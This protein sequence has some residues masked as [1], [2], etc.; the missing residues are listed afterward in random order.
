MVFS[1][2]SSL[3]HPSELRPRS[4][5]NSRLLP[6]FGDQ[7]PDGFLAG[8]GVL[9]HP[10]V[11]IVNADKAA[12][13]ERER[14]PKVVLPLS[15]VGAAPPPFCSGPALLPRRL[16]FGLQRSGLARSPIIEAP[17]R[18]GP[19]VEGGPEGQM[20]VP[21]RGVAALAR[22]DGIARQPKFMRH[23]AEL[24][25]V[26]PG[27]LGNIIARDAAVVPDAGALHGGIA[28]LADA[29]AQAL[30]GEEGGGRIMGRVVRPLLVVMVAVG[31][32]VS[33]IADARFPTQL[34]AAEQ[35]LARRGQSALPLDNN[36]H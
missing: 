14:P 5:D 13:A 28:Q 1:W 36:R 26:L 15:R 23:L 32:I 34:H 6:P 30:G 24:L 21:R 3:G 35:P 2:Y 8:D 18:R 17:A 19:A 31:I 11:P 7:L 20:F 25:Q 16:H 10:Q 9:E 27:D 33:V 12:V 29:A 22:E 4:V